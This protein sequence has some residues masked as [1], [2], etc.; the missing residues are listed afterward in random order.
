MFFG[1]IGIGTLLNGM[2]VLAYR[3]SDLYLSATLLLSALLMALLMC[4]LEALM[5]SFHGDPNA[6]AVFGVC[7]LL[8]LVTAYV[9]KR[10]TLV[11]DLQW[12]RRMIPHHS[13]ALTT[14]HRVL[15]RT[16]NPEIA[17]LAADIVA[18]QEREIALMKT[19]GNL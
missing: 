14:S 11:T 6:Q 15:E 7:G 19:L 2:N 4:C 13:T 16:K 17:K 8:A 1:S 12:L 10:Q 18:T 9:L 3:M 5:F